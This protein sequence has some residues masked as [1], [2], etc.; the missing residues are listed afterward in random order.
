ME[1]ETILI[2]L[3]SGNCPSIEISV[4]DSRGKLKKRS[5]NSS[6]LLIDLRSYCE[7]LL[8]SKYAHKLGGLIVVK[9][10]RGT[11]LEQRG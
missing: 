8:I 11:D 2:H 6:R 1:S 4:Y 3:V 5:L 10:E 7:S 9:Y